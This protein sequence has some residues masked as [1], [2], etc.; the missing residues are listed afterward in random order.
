MVTG[1][2]LIVTLYVHCLSCSA[3]H[4]WEKRE[5]TSLHRID[6]LV[7]VKQTVFVYSEAATWFSY[8]FYT[9]LSSPSV[10]SMP[11]K[12]TW[13]FWY[14]KWQGDRFLFSLE[15]WGFLVRISSL[16]LRARL[17]LNTTFTRSTRQRK[18]L[19]FKDAVLFQIS[20]SIWEKTN[21]TSFS[22]LKDKSAWRYFGKFADQVTTMNIQLYYKHGKRLF[23]SPNDA[24]RIQG[25]F[26]LLL[27]GWRRLFAVG[28]AE[29]SWNVPHTS[30]SYWG[31]ECVDLYLHALFLV[32]VVFNT[33]QGLYIYLTVNKNY[34]EWI[35]LATQST[36]QWNNNNQFQ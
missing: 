30:V 29:G 31:Q 14:T 7:S 16:T 26:N 28:Q 10:I 27:N 32:G 18:R 8:V 36:S 5:I 19:T 13:D 22:C 20:W 4:E 34:E 3:S 33:A 23:S 21:F 15:I 2:R 24:D 1:T 25:T 9:T 6:R 12:S 11:G 17:H 35:Q